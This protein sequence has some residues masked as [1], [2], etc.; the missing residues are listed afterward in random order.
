MHKTIF[1]IDEISQWSGKLFAWLLVILTGV[2]CHEVFMRYVMIRPSYWGYDASYMLYGALFFMAGAYALAQNAH[3]RANVLYRLWK[4]R[5]QASVD[6]VLY[7]IFFFPGVLALIY[8][9]WNFFHLS[10]LMNERSSF[11]PLGLPLYPLKFLIPLSGV[12]LAL[13]GL[14]ELMRCILCL[15]DGEWPPRLSDVRELEQ[16]IIDDPTKASEVLDT[17]ITGPQGG[18]RP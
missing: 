15:R 11:S 16:E 2:V 1:V 17:P 5:T 10:W 14:A 18:T 12:L 13:Q 4:P 3:V 9:G 8:S 7:I 6:L